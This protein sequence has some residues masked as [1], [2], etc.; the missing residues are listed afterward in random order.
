MGSKTRVFLS[1]RCYS[2]AWASCYA[3]SGRKTYIRRRF[4]AS[5]RREGL[6]LRCNHRRDIFLGDYLPSTYCQLFIE[7]TKLGTCSTYPEYS[8]WTSVSALVLQILI[9]GINSSVGGLRPSR[10]RSLRSFPSEQSQLSC[11]HNQWIFVEPTLLTGAILGTK[12]SLRYRSTWYSCAYP[13]PPCV[14]TYMPS[15]QILMPISHLLLAH[16]Q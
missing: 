8:S 4:I 14:S 6:T 15:V 7:P 5:P 16:T 3:T 9:F 13:I 1:G 12:H 2:L 11:A 10:Q